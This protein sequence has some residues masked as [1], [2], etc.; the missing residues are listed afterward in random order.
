[1][2]FYMRKY[3]LFTIQKDFSNVYKNNSYVLYKTLEN[4][5]KIKKTDF[6]YGLS[7]YNA[8]CQTFDVDLL[9]HYFRQKYKPHIISKKN[10]HI[11]YNRSQRCYVL[12]ELHYSCIIVLSN[13]NMPSILKD[14]NYYN[15]N[16]FVCDFI[17][18]DFF[19]LNKQYQK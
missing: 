2:D 16:I 18:E 9:N 3:Y 8:L 13:I 17:N 6:S 15:R 5:W 10:R 12:I 11:L 7:L 14:F 19:W 4:L 1:M